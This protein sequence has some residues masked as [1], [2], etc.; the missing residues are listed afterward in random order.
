MGP[1][2]TALFLVMVAMAG[3]GSSAC[4]AR[5][6]RRIPLRPDLGV[7]ADRGDVAGLSAL[8]LGPLCVIRAEMARGLMCSVGV[9]AAL[10]GGVRG[11]CSAGECG[12]LGSEV[13]AQFRCFGWYVN[14][15]V[16]SEPAWCFE[17]ALFVAVRALWIL[18]PSL[19]HSW[20]RL[21]GLGACYGAGVGVSLPVLDFVA[22]CTARVLP[23]FGARPFRCVGTLPFRGPRVSDIGLVNSGRGF[24]TGPFAWTASV[25]AVAPAVWG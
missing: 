18:V 4:S 12:M 25:G 19:A 15:F 17:W 13:R 11:G 6:I 24:C 7:W 20:I 10:V 21:L 23:Y 8:D 2:R 14:S 1:A 3:S 5:H 22:C 9:R 16:P